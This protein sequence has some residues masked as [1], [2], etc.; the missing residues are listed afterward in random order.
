MREILFRGKVKGK[1]KWHI[2]WYQPPFDYKWESTDG[3]VRHSDA[4][5]IFLNYAMRPDWT[6]VDEATVGQYTGLT[7]KN[8]T[9]IFEGDIVDVNGYAY[10]VCWNEDNVEF[11]IYNKDE[12]IGIAY[13]GAFNTEVI[14]NIYDNP[15]LIGGTE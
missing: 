9:K 1:N 5:I 12:S 13:I 2:G 4:M 15:E 11:G 14:G 3:E 6:V 10:A 7:D 8:G